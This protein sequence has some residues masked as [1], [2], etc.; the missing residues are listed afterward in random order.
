MVD[1]DASV[2]PDAD[3]PI[4]EQPDANIV[5]AANTVDEQ[6]VLSG[7]VWVLPETL[8]ASALAIDPTSLVVDGVVTNLYSTN[9]FAHAHGDIGSETLALQLEQSGFVAMESETGA[10][11]LNEAVGDMVIQQLATNGDEGADITLTVNDGGVYGTTQWQ[12][13]TGDRLVNGLVESSSAQREALDAAAVALSA[14]NIYITA[15]DSVGEENNLLGAQAVGTYT[16]TAGVD[17]YL[18]QPTANLVVAQMIAGKHITLEALSGSILGSGTFWGDTEEEH[19]LIA[20]DITLLAGADV[21][22]PQYGGESYDEPL[23]VYLKELDASFN[24]ALLAAGEEE[25]NLDTLGIRVIAGGNISIFS[26]FDL[27]VDFMRVDSEA[28]QKMAAMV[29]S[30]ESLEAY[31]TLVA[32]DAENPFQTLLYGGATDA[33]VIPVLNF[34]YETSAYG[35]AIAP[36]QDVTLRV[37]TYGDLINSRTISGYTAQQLYN[38]ALPDGARYGYVNFIAEYAYLHSSGTMGTESLPIMLWVTEALSL[39]ADGDATLE[40]RYQGLNLD[41]VLAL[42]D[43]NLIVDLDVTMNGTMVPGIDIGSMP[44]YANFL[45]VYGETNI[46]SNLGS[47]GTELQPLLL[48]RS[49]GVS[50]LAGENIYLTSSKTP[51]YIDNLKANNIIS[52]EAGYGIYGVGDASIEAAVVDLESRGVIGTAATPLQITAARTNLCAWGDVFL[53]FIGY[54]TLSGKTTGDASITGTS[55]LYLSSFTASGLAEFILAGNLRGTFVGDSLL[56]TVGGDVDLQTTIHAIEAIVGGNFTLEN[57]K[58]LFVGGISDLYNG[59]LAQGDILLIVDGILVLLEDVV[60]V[61]G[62]VTLIANA[63]YDGNGN[64]LDIE[65]S[66]TTPDAP[67]ENEDEPS[68]PAIDVPTAQTSQTNWVLVMGAMFLF[69]AL[70]GAGIYVFKK[71]KKEE[72]VDGEA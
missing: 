62:I 51:L 15:R 63:I 24:E 17:I 71:R 65:K 68:A 36:T 53:D 33:S 34:V 37:Y 70:C 14:S 61:D 18:Y 3:E 54:S 21:G 55:G 49:T 60:S 6:G 52:I 1:P 10:M 13:E 28:M 67:Q 7:T 57:S 43:F 32:Q 41:K 5:D 23:S 48:E 35:E 29:L 27:P 25:I 22:N 66:D 38:G 16:I 58:S 40:Q 44:M 42:Q 11:W 50:M 39:A 2:D 19:H 47:I 46:R 26:A 56:L 4:R 45:Y 64:R 30:G 72:D 12:D 20:S 69:L 9:L 31:Q 8:D 59:V